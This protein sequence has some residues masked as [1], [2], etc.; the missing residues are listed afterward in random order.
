[1]FTFFYAVITFNPDKMADSIQKRGGFVPWIRPGE[2]TAKYLNGVLMH[3]CLWWGIGLWLV[4]CYTYLLS[5]IPLVQTA[6]Q[7]IGQIPVIVQWSWV[8]I[9]VGVVQEL[10]TKVQSELLM[11]K[12]DRI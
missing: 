10:M 7:T 2:E 3:L 6:I 8:V 1:L 11:E 5:Y 9:I 12:Y 4:W